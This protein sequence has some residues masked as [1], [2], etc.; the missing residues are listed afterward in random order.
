MPRHVYRSQAWISS[1]VPRRIARKLPFE[2]EAVLCNGRDL[3]AL[4][5][6]NP[7]AA[8]PTRPDIVRFVSILSKAGRFHANHNSARRRVV[9]AS[10]RHEKPFRFRGCT[11]V[12]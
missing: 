5:M 8:E 12:T 9:R 10:H 7:F 3:I 1:K 2:T 11:V 6:E 4:E